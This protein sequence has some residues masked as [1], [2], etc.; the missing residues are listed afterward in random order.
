[1]PRWVK[2]ALEEIEANATRANE[3]AS[4]DGAVQPRIP[5]ATRLAPDD[6]SLW[7]NEEET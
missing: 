4:R 3:N 7:E 2:P 5:N 1:V 6:S